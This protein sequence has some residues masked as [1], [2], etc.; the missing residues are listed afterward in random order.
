VSVERHLSVKEAATELG[1][2]GWQIYEAVAKRELTV[3]R[4]TPKGRIRISRA[5]LD[6]WVKAHE[7]PGRHVPERTSVIDVPAPSA[8]RAGIEHLLP[9][10]SRR[11]SFAGRA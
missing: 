8:P 10:P 7:I 1:V 4:F 2:S 9:P 5:A 3:V 11:P 6:A